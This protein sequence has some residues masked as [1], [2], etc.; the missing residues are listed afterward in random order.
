MLFNIVKKLL[1]PA[2]I[3][4]QYGCASQESHGL[5]VVASTTLIGTILEEIG[6]DRVKVST[7]LPGGICPGHFDLKPSDMR[8]F[9]GAHMIFYQGWEPWIN[10]LLDSEDA[11]DSE[12][13][14]IFTEGNLMVPPLH[15]EAAREIA[16]I[17]RGKDPE[18]SAYYTE[19]LER[20]IKE[21]RDSKREILGRAE[22]FKGVRVVSSR[23]QKALLA[24][25]GF[26]VVATYKRADDMSPSD[27]ASV[28][29]IAREKNARAVIDNLQS[30][31]EDGKIIA[32]ETGI[33]QA[34][35]SNF[36]IDGSYISTLRNNF[37]KLE[38]I[39]K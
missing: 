21:I 38:T 23:H 8:A 22:S 6:E 1:I 28:I 29:R 13:L 24:W 35:L 30:G 39:I 37:A 14:S 34:A 36:P 7:I 15:I 9:S 19:N 18:N 5:T 27:Y 31:P 17:L 3:L 32:E 26:E 10:G 25:L 33:P 4:S 20:Y 11:R 16:E 2:I 12:K